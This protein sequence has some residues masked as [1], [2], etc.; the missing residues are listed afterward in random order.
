MA[1]AANK[2][3]SIK[4]LSIYNTPLPQPYAPPPQASVPS[5]QDMPLYRDTHASCDTPEM[6]ADHT[7]YKVAQRNAQPSLEAPIESGEKMPCTAAS[8][9][10]SLVSFD[11]TV[12]NA[13]P[14]LKA[15]VGG[16]SPDFGARASARGMPSLASDAL[17]D[18]LALMPPRICA[19]IERI[20]T[21]RVGRHSF[22]SEIRLRADGK[23]SIVIGGENVP[24]TPRICTG[25]LEVILAVLAEL[26]PTAYE[27]EICQG[28]ISR[29][30]G[31]RVGICRDR[32][33]D[34]R[35]RSL[36]FRLPGTECA[37]T[38]WL[39]DVWQ[40]RGR[41]GMLLFSAPGGGKTTAIK[42]LSRI[43]SVREHLRVVIIDERC[44]IPPHEYRGTT[45]DIVRGI[46]KSEGIIAAQR[47][48]SP[49]LIVTDELGGGDEADALLYAGRGGVPLLATVHAESVDEL[50]HRP[51]CKKLIDA[52]FFP[53]AVHL[54]RKNGLYL[55]RECEL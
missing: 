53:C 19:Q 8:S 41:G 30:S 55:A 24:L 26:S 11:P 46:P 5:R 14:A 9:T 36:I 21:S 28:F 3:P 4:H 27:H 2:K 17:T 1:L 39:F 13:R 18:T 29:E 31:V 35:L 33:G 45:V 51:A 22:I 15:S 6:W 40:A 52:G 12:Q 16:E 37:Y 34:R 47:T 20:R 50:M 48:L 42:A 23:S 32:G 44:E 25:E 10:Y 49:E 7:P 43:I 38:D 54:F